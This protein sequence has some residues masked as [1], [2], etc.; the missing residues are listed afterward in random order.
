MIKSSQEDPVLNNAT[1]AESA[2]AMTVNS[3]A[4]GLRQLL[5]WGMQM[6]KG[7]FPR[8]KDNC[9]L[10]E[11]GERMVTLH[12]MTLLCNCQTAMVR[13][14]QIMS[15]FMSRTPGF[16]SCGAAVTEDADGH[17]HW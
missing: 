15:V 9:R 16:Q 4:T 10:E 13:L 12:L 8:L 2:R 7:Q 1:E 6:I 14:N 17:L 5:E 11:F 3:Q